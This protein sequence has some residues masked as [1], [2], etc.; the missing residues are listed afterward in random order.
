MIVAQVSLLCARLRPLG[1]ILDDLQD[2]DCQV[3]ARRI[4]ALGKGEVARSRRSAHCLLV[5]TT[6]ER[7]PLA[8]RTRRLC[9]AS[10]LRGLPMHT[11]KFKDIYRS[12]RSAFFGAQMDHRRAN[13]ILL[14]LVAVTCG[15]YDPAMGAA[16]KPNQSPVDGTAHT[17]LLLSSLC[18]EIRR[19]AGAGEQCQAARRTA[20]RAKRVGFGN[21]RGAAGPGCRQARPLLRSLH[22]SL[23]TQFC[24]PRRT[25]CLLI[26]L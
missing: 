12:H 23:P 6:A 14:L 16:P 20:R 9:S 18:C 5:R 19:A 3:S 11:L 21:S 10:R 2:V 15:G 25:R 22:V 1:H 4:L 8:G 26:L 7:L 24:S 13:R 17:S